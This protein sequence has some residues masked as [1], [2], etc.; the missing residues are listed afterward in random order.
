LSTTPNENPGEELGDDLVV[1]AR[2]EADVERLAELLPLAHAHAF[3]EAESRLPG[4]FDL[5]VTL[6]GRG[7]DPGEL[8]AAERL[9]P[10]LA[11]EKPAALRVVRIPGWTRGVPLAEFLA[12]RPS[13]AT[14][15]GFAAWLGVLPGEPVP[16][17]RLTDAGNAARFA[18]QHGDDVRYCHT[19]RAWLVWDGRR[20]A[21]DVKNRVQELA[22]ATARSLYAEAAAEIDKGRRDELVKWAKATEKRERLAAMLSLAS[23]ADG[24][25][26]THAELDRDPWALNVENGTLDLR[27]GRLR[28]HDRDDLITKLCPAPFDPDAACPRW[29]ATLELVF[30]RPDPDDTHD[31]VGYWQRLCGYAITGVIREHV[32][33]IAYGTGSNGKSTVLEAFREMVGDYGVKCPPELLM[34]RKHEPHPTERTRLCGARVA[35]AIESES[36][37][38]LNEGL[39]KELTGGDRISAR[40]MRE[41]FWEFDP[42]HKLF[43]ATNHKPLIRG[44]DT[45]IWRRLKLVP[46]TNTI[47][48]DQADREMPGKLRAEFPGILAW[49]VRGCLLWQ[50]IGLEDPPEVAEATAE[51]RT[52]QDVLGRFLAE[53]TLRMPGA[54]V[55][56]R[57]LYRRYVAWAEAGGVRSPMTETAFGR[58]MGERRDT[59]KVRTSTGIAYLNIAMRPDV[60]GCEGSEDEPYTGHNGHSG[61]GSHKGTG[62]WAHA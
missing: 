41:D 56:S 2:D 61:N 15:A 44:T 51:Y 60:Q 3:A 42:T 58:E 27:T 36:G 8:R 24:V 35:V 30:R 18:F 7:D 21:H 40:R 52:D 10:R 9:R 59:H 4:A 38:R 26:I 53:E 34:A 29:L 23:S 48:D 45:G 49:A 16:E 55:K 39:V 17:Y 12:S 11:R 13:I 19:W 47:P 6:R 22:K 25:A 57:E 46:F 37:G 14:P 28:P 32:L 31:L 50:E 33:P 20:W 43:F 5:D 62:V 1:L 54:Q